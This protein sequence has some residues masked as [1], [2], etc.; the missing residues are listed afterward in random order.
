MGLNV[1]LN[2]FEGSTQNLVCVVTDCLDLVC[3]DPLFQDSVHVY[4]GLCRFFAASTCV[5]HGVRLGEG[6]L[7]VSWLCTVYGMVP[8]VSEILLCY[9][10]SCCLFGTSLPIVHCVFLSVCFCVSI[11]VSSCVCVCAAEPQL[12][13]WTRIAVRPSKLT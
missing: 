5:T 12:A 13:L 3:P 8:T 6:C 7:E 10:L 2:T 11:C 1:Q 9:C 4:V